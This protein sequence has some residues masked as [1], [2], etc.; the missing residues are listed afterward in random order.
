MS[1]FAD[2]HAVGFLKTG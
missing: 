2:I 1:N